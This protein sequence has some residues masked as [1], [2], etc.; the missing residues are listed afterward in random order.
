MDTVRL[1]T[2][3]MNLLR[4]INKKTNGKLQFM[5]SVFSGLNGI[6]FGDK[7]EILI[8]TKNQGV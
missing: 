7:R 1:K 8:A 3:K 4:F 6:E 2:L 5:D